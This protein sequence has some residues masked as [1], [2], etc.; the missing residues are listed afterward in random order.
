MPNQ[1]QNNAVAL[2]VVSFNGWENSLHLANREI[3]LVV[4][5]DVG[6][7]VVRCGFRNGPNLF[8]EIA[9]QQGGS[10]EP[11]WMIRGGHRFWA[12]PEEK[13]A[14]YELDNTPVPWTVCANGVILD[15]PPGPLTGLSKQLRIVL[16]G[17]ANRV[18]LRHTLTNTGRQPR[19]VAPW[20]LSVMAPLGFLVV[21]LPA[22]IAHA[23]RLTHNQNW[24]IWG[25][26]DFADGRWRLQR[27][28]LQFSHDPRCGPGKIGLA[29]REGWVAYHLPGGLFVKRFDWQ[30]GAIYPDG[31]VNFEAFANED[32]FEVESLGPM[33]RLMPGDAV[34]HQ[35]IWEIHP[36]LAQPA[37][38]AVLEYLGR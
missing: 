6:P 17:G 26:T 12:A 37:P 33:T 27:D 31:N 10:N 29:H 8:A 3:E 24:S 4:T 38:E 20:A 5:T 23:D 15:Q 30:E 32:F 34:S 19:E 14:T 21:P 28:Y 36:P 7:R 35:E 2:E 11:E 16:S 25:Y 1:E 18:E 9:G 22:K 13:P